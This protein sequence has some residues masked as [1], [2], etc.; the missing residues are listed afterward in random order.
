[1]TGSCVLSSTS[2]RS[3]VGWNFD[4]L[5]GKAP[6]LNVGFVFV[7]CRYLHEQKGCRFSN[8]KLTVWVF[9]WKLHTEC[10]LRSKR[11]Q[12]SYYAKVRAEAKKRLKGE[13]EG[14]RGNAC[15]QTPRFWKTPLDISRFGSSVNW[16]LVIKKNITNRLPLDYQICKITL[17]SNRTRC[18]RLQE[19]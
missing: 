13:G 18:R 15:P 4:P 17:V 8:E 9:A 2:G 6:R 14:R 5:A 16:Q 11:F 10:G 12:S 7:V 1:M 19:L 3:V